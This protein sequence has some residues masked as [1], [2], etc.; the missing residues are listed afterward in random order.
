[1]WTAAK[2][3]FLS[4]SICLLF[5][6]SASS[7]LAASPL[8]QDKKSNYFDFFTIYWENDFFS[9]TD[10]DYT[11]GIKFSWSTPF[12]EMEKTTLPEWSF[13]FF[14]KLPFVGK[15]SSSHAVSLSLGQDIYTP[16]DTESEAVVKD[17]RPYAGYTYL[18]AGFHSRKDRRKDSW[19]LRLGVVGPASLAEETQNVVHDL[20]G[21]DRAKGWDNQLENEPA[22][23][24]ICET[25]WR[26]WSVP[27]G[28]GLGFDVIPHLGGRIGTVNVY[29]NAG[30]EVR[31]GWDL[32]NDFGSC[33]IRGGCETNIA[34]TDHPVKVSTI[35]FFISADGKAVAHDIFLDG[36]LF[37]DSHNVDKELLVGELIGGVAWQRGAMKL[38][39][40]YIYRTRQFENQDDNQTYGSLSIAWLF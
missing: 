27:I 16:E 19:E 36:N 35:H 38:T 25:Q 11:N 3:K 7:V 34:F 22:V 33:P 31:F 29:L 20:I 40:S 24:L 2:S 12:G 37:Q 17:D 5:F 26:W 10:R 18:A 4:I 9:G 13:P 6:S 8:E 32:P 21:D 30:A 28:K 15:S 14:E 1:M 23:D 39:Y